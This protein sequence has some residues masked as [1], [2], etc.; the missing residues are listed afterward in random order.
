MFSHLSRKQEQNILQKNLTPG[1]GQ[2]KES[3]ARFAHISAGNSPLGWRDRTAVTSD[4][5]GTPV[6]PPG[7][8][9][10][11]LA[12]PLENSPVFR[13]SIFSIFL[14]SAPHSALLS[15]LQALQHRRGWE[16][17]L[18]QQHQGGAV[19]TSCK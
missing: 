19:L 11:V 14:P 18:C 17:G 7:F 13:E 10:R 15:L 12:L 2:K 9:S 6:F 4:G 1:P 5:P 8:L 16:H 3:G